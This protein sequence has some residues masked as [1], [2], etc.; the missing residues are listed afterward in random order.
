MGVMR[1]AMMKKEE[2]R[3]YDMRFRYHVRVN[4]VARAGFTSE[5]DAE[6]WAAAHGGEVWE[7]ARNPRWAGREPRYTDGERDGIVEAVGGG[8]SY[9]KAAEKF[10]CSIGFVHKLINEHREKGGK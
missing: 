7:A 8:M 6:E 2:A 5:G 9:R 4:G 1:R 10:G 3:G